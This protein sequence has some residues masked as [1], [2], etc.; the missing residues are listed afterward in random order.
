MITTRTIGSMLRG[1][2][3]STRVQKLPVPKLL[4]SVKVKGRSKKLKSK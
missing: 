4:R 3:P 2:R 1:V